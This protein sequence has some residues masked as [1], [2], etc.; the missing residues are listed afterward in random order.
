MDEMTMV[1]DLG[2]VL[3]PVG[4]SPEELRQRVLGAIASDQPGPMRTRPRGPAGWCRRW[5][6]P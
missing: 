3:T 4:R 2:E 5:P 6:R 1:K